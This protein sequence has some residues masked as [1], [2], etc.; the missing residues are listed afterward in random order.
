MLLASDTKVDLSSRHRVERMVFTNTN[1]ISSH[2]TSTTLTYDNR[3]RVSLFS[4][5]EL[6]AQIFRVRIREVFRTTACFLV[7]IALKYF[8]SW[9]RDSI[10]GILKDKGVSTSQKATGS[11]VFLVINTSNRETLFYPRALF[12]LTAIGAF[13]LGRL[14]VLYEQSPPIILEYGTTP[15]PT[16][17]H[18]IVK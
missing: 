5:I 1:V 15:D 2:N 18:L 9:K 6:Y 14:S 16:K 4:L 8:Y 12:I 17:A 7:A 13:A 11:R 10:R 3:A